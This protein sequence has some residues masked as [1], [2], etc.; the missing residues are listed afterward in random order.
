VNGEWAPMGLN[1]T[2]LLMHCS[3]PSRRFPGASRLKESSMIRSAPSCFAPLRTP[4]EW[5]RGFPGGAASCRRPFPPVR[6]D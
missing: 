2:A 6:W 3:R 5:A 4:D 1:G